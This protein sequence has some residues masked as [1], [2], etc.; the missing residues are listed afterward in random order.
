MPTMSRPLLAVALGGVLAF[1]SPA[2]AEAPPAADGLEV[3]QAYVA[4]Y[5]SRDLD[6]MMALMHQEVE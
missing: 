2:S 1:A 3:A 5:N 6:A 4:A